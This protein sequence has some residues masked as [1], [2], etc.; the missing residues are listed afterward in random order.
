MSSPEIYDLAFD[1]ENEEK[2]AQRGIFQEDALDVIA[3]LHILVRNRGRRRGL[4]KVIGRDWAGRFLT[5]ILEATTIRTTWRPV[6]GWPSSRAEI[7]KFRG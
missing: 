5:I 1:D 7:K 4:Y 3:Q 2:L 6:T